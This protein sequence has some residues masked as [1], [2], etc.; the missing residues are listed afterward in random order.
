MVGEAK[1]IATST[2]D[3]VAF[4]YVPKER[5]DKEIFKRRFGSSEVENDGVTYSMTKP[6]LHFCFR[7]PTPTLDKYSWVMSVPPYADRMMT[8]VAIPS[9][10]THNTPDGI[11]ATFTPEHAAQTAGMTLI[12]FYKETDAAE[13][14]ASLENGIGVSQG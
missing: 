5:I 12:H 8:A 1:T 6:K 9:S 3:E 13:F 10:T 7:G 14:Q 11:I 2:A 4:I